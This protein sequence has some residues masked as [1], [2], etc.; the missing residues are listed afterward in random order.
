[1][2]VS[3]GLA[4]NGQPLGYPNLEIAFHID[5][6]LAVLPLIASFHRRTGP[7][8]G[9]FRYMNALLQGPAT[10]ELAESPA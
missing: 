7:F 3:L 5:T 10:I 2:Q 1:L 6:W 4:G 8:M 9:G